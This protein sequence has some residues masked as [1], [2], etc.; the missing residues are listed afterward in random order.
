MTGMG[1]VRCSRAPH[2]GP[3][4]LG[5]VTYGRDG[6]TVWANCHIHTHGS[7]RCGIVR[8]DV[9][10]FKLAHWLALGQPAAE[11]ASPEDRRAL[12]AAHRLRWQREGPLE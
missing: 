11:G 10:R 1:Y 6:R 5:L 3:D 2:D 8:S 4:V 12:G 9:P 7:I